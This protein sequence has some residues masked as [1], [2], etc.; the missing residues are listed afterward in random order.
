MYRKHSEIVHQSAGLYRSVSKAGFRQMRKMGSEY[1]PLTYDNLSKSLHTFPPGFYHSLLSFKTSGLLW[2]LR[3]SSAFFILYPRCSDA[4]RS[5]TCNK[6]H[7][8]RAD[9]KSPLFL[10]LNI[11]KQALT[12]RLQ[13]YIYD[14]SM[15]YHWSDQIINN[16]ARLVYPDIFSIRSR[17]A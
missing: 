9:P 10:R 8:S 1:Q 15:I 11:T 17:K 5:N 7:M 14:Y 3:K 2:P 16:V 4:N 6:C 12:I 13:C